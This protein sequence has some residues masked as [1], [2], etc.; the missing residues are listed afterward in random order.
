[1]DRERSGNEICVAPLAETRRRAS[2]WS[3]AVAAL[4]GLALLTG[5]LAAVPVSRRAVATDGATAGTVRF[6]VLPPPD[7]TWSPAPTAWTAQLALSPDGSRLAFVAARA[8]EPS[9]IWIRPLDRLD[10]SAVPGT[11]GAA[12]PFWSPDGRFMAFFADGRLKKVDVALGTPQALAEVAAARGGAWSPSG[13]IVFAQST[14]P[15]S[16]VPADG[17]PVTPATSFDLEQDPVWHYWPRFL[18]DGRRFLFLQ[19]SGKPEYQGIYVGSLD[20][21]TITRLLPADVRGLYASG[22]LLFIR[23]GLLFAQTLD[24][25]TVRL[26]SEPV[27]IADGVGVYAFAFGYSAVDVSSS[28]VVAIGPLRTQRVIQSRARSLHPGLHPTSERSPYPAEKSGRTTTSGSSISP[29]A[30]RRASRSTPTRT[31][32]RPGCR[33]DSTSC[34]PQRAR[35]VA[36]AP[37]P[38][39]GRPSAGT[40]STSRW[41]QRRGVIPKT[42]LRTVSSSW[43]RT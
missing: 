35:Q 16:Q 3:S 20:S 28:G 26:T 19:R 40:A 2:R 29:G 24:L 25:D 32:F 5:A 6:E 42:C 30:S 10:A 8:G 41:A 33:M 1:V 43:S 34:S 17:G 38:S 37:T 22:N 39:I 27:R 12:Y 18:P 21:N 15:L 9:R 14:S 13:V 4:L 36:P 7:A 11:E 31:G 23:D